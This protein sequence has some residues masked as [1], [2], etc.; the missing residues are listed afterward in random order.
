MRTEQPVMH[1]GSMGMYLVTRHDLVL[2]IVRD[3]DTYSSQI[4]YGKHANAR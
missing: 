1:L 2:Q 4:R 3:V